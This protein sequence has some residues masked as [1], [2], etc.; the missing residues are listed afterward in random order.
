M[1]KRRKCA[2]NNKK[3]YFEHHAKHSF[4]SQNTQQPDSLDYS[5]KRALFKCL[6]INRNQTQ[7]YFISKS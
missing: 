7:K 1:E 3:Y 6:P 4:D 5:M 2:K